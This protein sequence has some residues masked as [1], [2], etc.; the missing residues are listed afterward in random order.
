MTHLLS[1]R[2]ITHFIAGGGTGSVPS[3]KKD[4]K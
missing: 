2:L 1:F 3:L 4:K